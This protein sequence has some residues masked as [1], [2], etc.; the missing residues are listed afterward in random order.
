MIPIFIK[1]GL[2][3]EKLAK[4]AS[5]FGLGQKTTIDMAGEVDGVVPTPAWK[6]EVLG[7]DWYDGNTLHFAIGQGYL[8][9]TPLQVAMYTSAIAN[10]GLI[11]P[12]QIVG[13]SDIPKDIGATPTTIATIKPL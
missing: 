2:G 1:Q 8:L 5:N 10:N 4:W 3:P 13:E 6:K 12:P 9:T 11:F 7:E